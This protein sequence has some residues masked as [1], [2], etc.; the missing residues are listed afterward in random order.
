[1]KTFSTCAL[2]TIVLLISFSC[3]KDFTT[4]PSSGNLTFSADTVFL[5]TVFKNISTSTYALKVYNNSTDDVSIPSINLG[6]ADSYYRLNVDGLPGTSF[7]NILLR[8]K[9]SLFIFI[10]GTIDYNPLNPLYTDSIVFDS[11]AKLQN[12]KLVTLVQDANF[13]YVN[14]LTDTETVTPYFIRDAQEIKVHEMTDDQIGYFN[15][16]NEKESTV[17]YGYCSVPAGKILTIDKGKK[18][19][20]HKNSALIIEKDATLTINGTLEEKVFIEGDRLEPEFREN[21]GQWDAIWL[22]AGSK[23][24]T[25]NY[26]N[27]RNGTF[28]IVC[29]SISTDGTLPTLRI[30]N[31]EIYNTSQIGLL[32]N[33]SNIIGVNMVIGNSR[34][35]SFSAIN[36]GVYNINHSTFANY[37]SESI[38]RGSTLQISNANTYDNLENPTLP[39]DAN[40]SNTVIDGNNTNELVLEKNETDTFG[41][42]F[43]NCV[44]KYS[45]IEDDEL[46]NFQDENHYIDVYLNL[47]GDYKDTALNEF[48][49]GENSEFQEKA[50]IPVNTQAT[51]DI[52][53]ND[54]TAS[55]DIGAYQYTIPPEE[56]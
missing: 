5:D 33:N 44:I 52:L 24:N 22:R 26:L 30:T 53:G 19:Y 16:E 50:G 37:W 1:M 55:P 41:F 23:N 15:N 56:E 54:R 45:N 35:T 9:D 25:I 46:Y 20:F 3:R 11:G 48:N 17:I 43:E 40:F 13:I 18:I 21:A 7:E 10:E 32:A 4:I 38:R 51:N 14:N 47:S 27:S 28:G 12:V 2:L 31:S 6:R 39:L 42:L 29:D 34:I 49:I 36:G 8:A